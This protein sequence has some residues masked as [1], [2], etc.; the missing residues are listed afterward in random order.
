MLSGV[1]WL[2]YRYTRF[3]LDHARGGRERGGRRDPRALSRC[4]RDGQLGRGRR[5]R[6]TRR[7]PR[8]ADHRSV[9]QPDPAAAR[10][11]ARRSARRQLHVVPAHAL[12]AAC[13][14][15]SS[16]PSCT[17]GAD[18]I[19]EFLRGTGLVEVGAVPRDHRRAQRPRPARCPF[20]SHVNERMP[21]LGGRIGSAW[22]PSSSC[23]RHLR[24][25]R[26]GGVPRI[27]GVHLNWVAAATTTLI[28]AT[29]CLS[30]VVVTGYTGQ[31]SLAQYALAG[32]GAYIASRAASGGELIELFSFGR[33]DFEV[34]LVLGV[35][36]AVPIGLLVGLPALRTRGVNLAI[37]TLGSRAAD[38]A[39]RA[40]RMP[41]TRAASR[42]PSCRVRTSSGSISIR[43]RTRAATRCSASIAVRVAALIV[44][45]LRRGRSGR[46]LVAVRT[47]ERAAASLGHLGDRREALRLRARGRHR[48]TRRHPARVPHLAPCSS[49]PTTC[50]TRSRSSCRRCSAGIGFIGGAI[51]GGAIAIGGAISYAMNELLDI[52]DLL[53]ILLSGIF[54]I[55]NLILFPDGVVR[56]DGAR[57]RTAAGPRATDGPCIAPEPAL[58]PLPDVEREPIR[59]RLLAVEHVRVRFGGV[60]AV[61]DVSLERAARRGLG[62]IGPNGAGKTTLIDVVTGF[63]KPPDVDRSRSTSSRDRRL[64]AAASSSRRHR[65]VVPVARAVRGHDGAGQP[66]NRVRSPRSA[67]VPHRP[68]VAPQ[69]RRSP[70]PQSRRSGSSG[71]RATS[72]GSPRPCRTVADAL[73]G[74]A[75]AVATQP[76]VLL[77]DEP[78][79]GL[80]EAE[81]RGAERARHPP[82][83]GVGPRRPARRARRGAGD[84]GLRPHRRARLRTASSPRAP[85]TRSAATRP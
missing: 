72:I 68:R 27:D 50:S 60:V 66:P 51:F 85:P 12:R 71:S 83:Q 20:R 48:R 35:V 25:A 77:L 38:R 28:A 33:V 17:S 15:A 73:V 82:R 55:F 40:R 14:S 80:D 44:A 63:T 37:A 70:A 22:C 26:R 46:R 81:T 57:P 2:V 42:G 8:G 56:R 74:I 53:I 21:G 52:D 49:R 7:D 43:S 47:N 67:R 5:P 62:L 19:P 34:A 59:R 31:L 30:L 1:L 9:G 18:W 65:A 24:A 4:D 79:A 11:V 16:R 69:P 13:S 41:T 75:R 32:I 3:G 36:L 10:P 54:L 45:N 6:R 39:R 58:A 23:P 84:G 76:S 29:I 61:D 78:A 64:V